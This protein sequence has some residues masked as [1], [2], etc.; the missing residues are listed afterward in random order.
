LREAK[1]IHPT[2]TETFRCINSACEDNCCK[3]WTIPVDK[4]AIEK[5]KKLP[6]SPLHTLIDASILLAAPGRE[7]GDSHTHSPRPAIFAS[8][9]TNESNHCPLLSE[10]RLCA[11]QVAY[12]EALLPSACAT[13][14]RIVRWIGNREEKS[15]T[16]SC[17][18]AARLV[19]LNPDLL[20]PSHQTITEPLYGQLHA[21]SPRATDRAEDAQ[22]LRPWFWSIRES[23]FALI[24][25]RGYP[26]WQRLFLLG[27]FCRQLDDLRQGE[28]EHLLPEFLRDFEAQVATGTSQA[29]MDALP[30]ERTLQLDV[31]LR[32]AGMLLHRPIVNPRFAECVESFTAGIGNG[33]SATLESLA[34]NYALA[35]D[36]FYAP[37]FERHP[38][39]LENYLINTIFRCQFPF[40]RDGMESGATPSF[41][42][43]Y[44]TLTAQFALIKGLLIG[45]SGYHRDAFSTDHVVHTLQSA[46]KHFEHHVEFLRDAHALLVES[47]M[48]DARGSLILLKNTEPV[49]PKP[50]LPALPPDNWPLLPLPGKIPSYRYRRPPEPPAIPS[51]IA[52]SVA[53]KGIKQPPVR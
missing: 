22:S 19:L 33:P 27:I 26:L 38:Y 14:P 23:V 52:L 5:Y 41:S 34:S 16:L 3:S 6:P 15:L 17:P 24:G 50:G 1:L 25:N 39:I 20:S 45:V 7:D 30:V 8:I 44:A 51:T 18:E 49:A 40:G 4:A 43:E 2:Y 42:R 11:I 10:E 9:R 29:A 28:R 37:F 12:G 36:K 31:V 35:H 47:Q 21:G 13:Y 46:S 53:D 48:D 32:L